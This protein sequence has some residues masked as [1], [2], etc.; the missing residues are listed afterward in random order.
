MTR[1]TG[2]AL[3]ATAA[4]VASFARHVLKPLAVAAGTSVSLVK[5]LPK[6]LAA[7]VSSAATLTKS[8]PRTLSTA[9]ASS[10]SLSRRMGK[11]LAATAASSVSLVRRVGKSLTTTA[12]S[13]ATLG[14]LISKVLAT[15]TAAVASI[16]RVV[17]RFIQQ[18]LAL[19][20]K[21]SL[22]SGALRRIVAF[23][24]SEKS[25]VV[26][27]A[28]ESAVAA[29]PARYISITTV[30]PDEMTFKAGT[31]IQFETTFTDADGALYDPDTGTVKM[32]VKKPDGTYYT[33]YAYGVSGVVMT[34][35][36]TG[37]YRGTFQTNRTDPTGNWTLEVEGY[38]G[39]E[40]SFDDLKFQVRA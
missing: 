4:S 29:R 19:A 5:R 16:A 33:G 18:Q 17:N 39:S 37:V 11:P 35:I 8:L 7:S 24:A 38:V 21:T 27:D 25:S 34:K 36:S 22:V 23:T 9:V 6:T 28:R 32:Y 1:I 40:R 13:T 3:S 12:P 10:A 26:I 20:A 14:R 15:S 2:K 30:G 31:A